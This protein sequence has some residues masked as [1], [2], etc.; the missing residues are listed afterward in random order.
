M[1]RK[2]LAGL[3]VVGLVVSGCSALG[4]SG[5]APANESQGKVTT[6]G[7]AVSAGGVTVQGPGGVA[8]EGTPVTIDEVPVPSGIAELG[9]TGSPMFTIALDGGAQPTAP[10]SVT[11]PVPEGLAAETIAFVAADGPESSWRGAPVTVAEGTAKVELESLGHGWFVDGAAQAR[12]FTEGAG[13]FTGQSYP[14]PEGCSQSIRQGANEI[15]AGSSQ[16]EMVQACVANEGGKTVLTLVSRSAEVLALHLQPGATLT[17]VSAGPSVESALTLAAAGDGPVLVP[18]GSVVVEYAPASWS[19]QDLPAVTG[20]PAAG[21][22]LIPLAVSGFRSLV[23]EQN[24]DG[25]A[26]NTAVVECLAGAAERASLGEL[27]ECV[28]LGSGASDHGVLSGIVG[29]L[30]GHLEPQIRG[31]GDAPAAGEFVVTANRRVMQVDDLSAYKL[32]ATGLG[33][34]RIGTPMSQVL[35]NGWGKR[36]DDCG[37]W[38]PSER[39]TDQGV[40]FNPWLGSDDGTL[41]EVSV[42]TSKIPTAS[43]ARVGM[44][45]NQLREIYGN[46]LRSEIKQTSGGP[47]TTHFVTSGGHEIIFWF[48]GSTVQQMHAR[49]YSEHVFSNC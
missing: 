28:A 37:P 33:P 31:T 12:A 18:G 45:L 15:V 34:L 8:P 11:W 26:D 10:V 27:V 3:V 39:L 20:A 32:E 30:A 1:A 49:E 7:F 5:L 14:A 19:G 2:L 21:L 48:E 41:R 22:S 23:P 9:L 24:L 13:G 43:G 42:Q 47:S 44:T 35:A 46:R 25:L 16:G 6:D 17:K 40:M 36:V 38:W 29:S 4:G